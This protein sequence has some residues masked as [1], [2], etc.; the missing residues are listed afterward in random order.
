MRVLRADEAAALVPEGATIAML[1]QGGAQVE[2]RTIYRALGERYAATGSPG[3]LTLIHSGGIGDRG[4]E[5]L[6]RCAQPGMTK[7]VM[8]GHWAWSAQMQKLAVDGE[9]EAYNL[10]QGVICQQYREI[11]A[12]RPGLITR[13]GLGTFV[14]PRVEGARLNTRTTEQLVE[15]ITIDGVEYLHYKPWRIDVG[16]IRATTADLDGN[17]VFTDEVAF[18]EAR[19]I[20]AAAHNCNGLVIAQVKQLAERGTLDPQLVQV[21]GIL[22]DV[23]VVDP[24]QQQTCQGDDD[25]LSGRIRRPAAA[26]SAMPL[27]QRKVIARRAACVL[28]PGQ[29][30]NLGVGIPD[31]IASVAHEEHLAGFTSTIEQGL[32][33][34]VPSRGDLFGSAA[35]PQAFVPAPDQFDFY[36]GGGLDLAC[37]GMAQLDAHGNVNVSR[38]GPTIAGCGGFIDISQ[39]AREVVFCGTF[40]ADGLRTTVGDGRLE[41]VQEGRIGK[42]VEQVEQITFSGA[43][44]VARGQR[45]TY[46]TERAVFRLEADGPVLIEIAPGIDLRRQVLDLM[47]FT[48]RVAEDL[49]VMDER[50]FRDQ[51]MD[52]PTILE[53]GESR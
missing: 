48:P 50:I 25:A 40:T 11:A 36:A 35:N 28:R 27:D 42:L 16:I 9:I 29:V 18:L 24:T 47:E 15:V 34:G 31:G 12:G 44:A 19:A 46:V 30:I 13:V 4:A 26:F 2:P 10:P 7:R 52:L 43:Q 23:V 22:V 6:S 32:V 1:G 8:G 53:Q 14:D 39:S 20:A 45:V 41:I 5:G 38:F 17:L 3:A 33:G 37:L 51:L 49:R 21:P